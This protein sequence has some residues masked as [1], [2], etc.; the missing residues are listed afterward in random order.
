[1]V[2]THD[3]YLVL[4]DYVKGR[5][6]CPA[7]C[8]S[9]RG[10]RKH[11]T[12]NSNEPSN[13]IARLHALD[14]GVH[15][16]GAAAVAHRHRAGDPCRVAQRCRRERSRLG[17]AHGSVRD[18]AE[19]GR[20]RERDHAA[21]LWPG[22]GKPITFARSRAA[23]CWRG[24]SRR[25]RRRSNDSC[26]SRAPR[27]RHGRTQLGAP[28]RPGDGAGRARLAARCAEPLAHRTRMG[29]RWQRPGAVG[30]G[31]LLRCARRRRAASATDLPA[32]EVE[33]RRPLRARVVGNHA[34]RSAGDDRG[35]RVV[36]SARGTDVREFHGT[37]YAATG[38][39]PICIAEE[40]EMPEPA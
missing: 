5:R 3:L 18:V 24:P 23:R 2:P 10:S 26:L 38:S 17:R 40:R 33:A 31:A 1:M 8:W 36:D 21:P 11:S 20:G 13:T 35:H 34:R 7:T 15:P 6:A 12:G 22:H 30:A 32:R 27:A 9:I 37:Q 4:Q 25:S 28:R 19:G 29:V 39:C 14:A 16:R